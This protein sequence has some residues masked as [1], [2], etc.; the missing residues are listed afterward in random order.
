MVMRGIKPLVGL[1]FVALVLVSV[2]SI[3]IVISP[4]HQPV[5]EGTIDWESLKPYPEGVISKELLEKLKTMRYDEYVRVTITVRPK[6]K[7]PSVIELEIKTGLLEERN[8][9]R[10]FAA[11]V[12]AQREAARL[13]WPFINMTHLEL[14]ERQAKLWLENITRRMDEIRAFVNRESQRVAKITMDE[15]IPQLL[16]VKSIKDLYIGEE[17]HAG[18]FATP[19]AIHELARNPM[20]AEIS[21]TLAGRVTLDI[22]ARAVGANAYWAGGN[23]GS[24]VKVATIDSGIN[25]TASFGVLPENSRSFVPTEEPED[26]LRRLDGI[27]RHSTTPIPRSIPKD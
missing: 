11:R 24:V 8:R 17:M 1:S 27:I 20:V 16:K 19:P 21:L 10:D 7:I 9:Y 14:E 23:I 18:L 13:G 26:M 6:E 5:S 25:N 2:F 15:F 4:A 12:G 3:G 22:S